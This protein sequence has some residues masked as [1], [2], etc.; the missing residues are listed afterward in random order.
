MALR[1]LALSEPDS[2][3]AR[4]RR[5]GQLMA[6]AERL[7]RR[8]LPTQLWLVEHAVRRGNVD[9][10]LKHFDIALRT[11]LRTRDTIFAMLASAA[12]SDAHIESAL[13]ASLRQRPIWAL[14]FLAYLADQGRDPALMTNYSVGLLD[15]HRP[16]ELKLVNS[17]IVRLGELQKYDLAWT[18]Y[19]HW[20]LNRR[21]RG[22]GALVQNGGFENSRTFAPFGWA[23]TEDSDLWAARERDPNGKGTVLRV[24]S[25]DGRSGSAARQLIK[26]TPGSY[27]LRA[28]FGDIAGPERSWPTVTVACATGPIG[29]SLAT[30]RPAAARPGPTTIEARF[31]VPPGCQFQWIGISVRAPDVDSDTQ[32]W[33]DD[34]SVSSSAIR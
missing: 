10:A 28:R 14:P 27:R 5:A 3:E 7:S 9:A 30:M 19:S 21:P 17:T 33:I 13:A 16:E 29:N 18:L 1:A 6:Q 31:T 20:G 26:L 32:P 25:R 34:V 15:V 2:A 11:S 23:L 4:P 24:G 22:D 8:D 12:A